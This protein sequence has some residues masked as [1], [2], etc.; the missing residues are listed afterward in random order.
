MHFDHHLLTVFST[1]LS[2]ICLLACAMPTT[3]SA[4]SGEI[5][6]KPFG[7]MP[8]G[9]P[10]DLYTLRN[11][12]RMEVKIS[13]YGG[14]VV[15]ISVPDRNGQFADVVLGYDNLAG[16]LKANPF[17]GAMVGR[18]GNRIAQAKFTLN[19]KEYKLAANNNGNA[20]H[21]GLKGFDKV[22]W[23]A[24]TA[25]TSAGPSLELRYVSRD[26]EEGYPGTLSV[27]AVYTLTEDNGLRLDYTATTDKDTVL[28]LTQHS[29]F[30]LAGKG[31][32]L[33]H[34]VM[35]DADRFTPVDATLIPTGEL[36][37]VQGTPFDFRK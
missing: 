29:Y 5:S 27:T 24:K 19:G 14:I 11:R 4:A 32:I 10:V 35:I 18:Y 3:A 13:N 23:D 33:N 26:G 37:P 1:S 36:R 30:N 8:D 25:A 2:T 15:S 12:H 16:Y 7:K 34:E 6:K 20:L 21:G 22:V 28:N 31:D 9:T 17:F